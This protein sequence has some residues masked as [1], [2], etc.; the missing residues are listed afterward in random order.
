MKHLQDL[1]TSPVIYLVPIAIAIFFVWYI[2]RQRIKRRLKHYGRHQLIN[3]DGKP[4]QQLIYPSMMTMP[5]IT[6]R[7]SK[8]RWVKIKILKYTK[9]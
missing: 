3:V 5:L 9:K 4:V 8:L 1:L 7:Y 6:L 2:Q